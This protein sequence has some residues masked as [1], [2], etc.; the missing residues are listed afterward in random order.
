LSPNLVSCI[1]SS[2]TETRFQRLLQTTVR[3]VFW[4]KKIPKL[5][6]RGLPFFFLFFFPF[7]KYL[8]LQSP[9]P[10]FPI[11][12]GLTR[13]FGI[14]FGGGSVAAQLFSSISPGAFFLT[15]HQSKPVPGG[16]WLSEGAIHMSFQPDL[17]FFCLR[18]YSG[19]CRKFFGYPI[20]LQCLLT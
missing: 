5:L 2:H 12:L 8:P 9:G 1:Q 17:G 10:L 3:G 20:D 18:I 4:L 6:L 13:G 7:C 15:F 11:L 19:T 16:V 14:F